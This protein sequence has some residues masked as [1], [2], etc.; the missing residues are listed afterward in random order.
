MVWNDFFDII[1]NFEINCDTVLIS[2]RVC[3]PVFL[4]IFSS[5]WFEFCV[6]WYTYMVNSFLYFCPYSSITF[7]AIIILG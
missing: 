3:L 6:L 1:H 7:G 4:I 2:S 5:Y